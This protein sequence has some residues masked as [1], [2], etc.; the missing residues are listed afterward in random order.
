MN[1]QKSLVVGVFF[2]L[3]FLLSSCKSEPQVIEVTREVTRIVVVTA[4]PVPAT[5]TPE[6]TPTPVF[7]KWTTQN[8]IDIFKAS[9]LEAENSY[10]MTKDDYGAAP[11]RAIEAIR[12]FIPSMCSDCGGRILSFSNQE[13]L[14]ITKTYYDEL[15][16]SS[17]WFFSWIFIKDNILIQINGD[18]PEDKAKAYEMA[19]NNL[20]K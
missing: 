10:P 17:A 12:F 6:P 4:T 9:G 14:E 8:V 18:L 7:V 16:K 15:G 1:R 2:V 19:L 5:S 11:M 3:T 20:L 13:D